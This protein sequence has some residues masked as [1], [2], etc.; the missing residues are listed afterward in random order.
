MTGREGDPF[1]YRK[2]IEMEMRRTT[3]PAVLAMALVLLIALAFGSIRAENAVAAPAAAVTPVAAT[4]PN[5]GGET[6]VIKFYAAERLTADDQECR[7][8]R[9]YRVIDL[10]FVVDQ[11]DTNTTTVTLEHSN[12]AGATLAVNTTGQTVVSANA[13]DA[14]DLNR[15]DLY[16]AFTCVDINVTNSNPVTWTVYAVARK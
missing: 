3:Y 13:A 5:G 11:T 2:E 12:G 7:D 4:L 9:E 10:E 8:L 15:F 16:G 14:D 1:P 6:A